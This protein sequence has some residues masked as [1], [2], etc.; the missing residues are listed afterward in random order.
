MV[1]W[2]T[3]AG[4]ASAQVIDILHSFVGGVNDGSAPGGSLLLS[5]SMLYGTT[6]SGGTGGDGTI[7]QLG[8]NGAGYAVT[9]S[10]Q[11]GADNGRNPNGS[12][13]Q[14]GSTLY[15]L[16]VGGGTGE[17]TVFQTGVGGSGFGLVYQFAGPPGDG[18]G[19]VGSLAVSGSA[20]FGMTEV[21][22][23]ANLGTVFKVNTDGSGETVLHSFTGSPADGQH[24]LYATPV[25]SGS[26]IYGMTFGGGAGGV[27]AGMIFKENTDGT[28]YV[29]LHSFMG[30]V[31]DGLTPY[32]SLT[33]S[34]NELYGMTSQGGSAN[35]GTIFEMNINGTGFGLLRSFTGGAADGASPE[36]GLLI[37][38]SEMY[39]MTALG[40]A[41]ALGTIFGV[42]TDGSNFSV[43]YS[44]TGG[45]S[46]GLEPQ[47][48][49]V[50]DGSNLYGMTPGGGPAN[51]GVV[52]SLP[53]AVPEPSSFFL[54]AAWAATAAFIAF[55]RR[56]RRC[57]EPKTPAKVA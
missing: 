5:G 49:L 34:G 37:S 7:F 55:R 18:A 29:V 33:L 17:G 35:K 51:E 27:A 26:T 23:S 40:G 12:L 19:P 6:I 15:G 28:G 16:T 30:G 36:C 24:P 53:V 22:G 48:D 8:T 32:G 38:G 10:F 44:F 1:G 11:N 54:S 52:F 47:G 9:H 4:A 39:G 46:D 25:V 56:L 3:L 2:L 41:D 14:A 42:H 31:N 20:L 43:L 50:F 21:G 45:A 13:V 57:P